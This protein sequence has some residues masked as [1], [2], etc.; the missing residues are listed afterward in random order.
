MFSLG[1]QE[2]KVNV[3]ERPRPMRSCEKSC[4]SREV[5]VTNNGGVVGMCESS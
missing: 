5:S 1:F 4:D 3:I 2:M